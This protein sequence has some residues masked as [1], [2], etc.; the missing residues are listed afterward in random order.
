MKKLLQLLLRIAL[1]AAVGIY[2]ISL[3]KRTCMKLIHKQSGFVVAQQQDTALK[4]NDPFLEKELKIKGITI[5]VALRKD[6]DGK[7]VIMMDDPLF[8]K[9]FKEVYMK[10]SMKE[11]MYQWTDNSHS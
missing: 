5:P 9:A 3:L 7:S 1:G 2:V 11:E 6:Y 8:P 10:L 4:I